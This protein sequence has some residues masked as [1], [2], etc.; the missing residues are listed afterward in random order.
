[1]LYALIALFVICCIATH[2]EVVIKEMKNNN[3][4]PYYF[5]KIVMFITGIAIIIQL[6]IMF[7]HN[8]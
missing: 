7:I 3:S 4:F 1:M 2:D 6:V 8:K 5:I